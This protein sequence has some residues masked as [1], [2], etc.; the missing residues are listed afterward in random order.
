MI[1]DSLKRGVGAGV[2]AGLAYGLFMAFVGNPLIEYMEHFAH[3]HGHGH[4]PAVS[5]LTTTVVS[6]GSGVLWGILLGTVFGVAYYLLEP[7]L[8]GTRG[9]R[10]TVLAG[11]GFL[12]VSG[13]PWLGLPPATPVTEQALATDT[14]LLVY[15]GLM[16]LGAMMC[17]LSIAAFQRLRTR[18]TALALG[19]ATAPFVLAVL[20]VVL[21]PSGHTDAPG[22]LVTAFQSLVVMSQV[23]IWALIA[24]TYTRLGRGDLAEPS[25]NDLDESHVVTGD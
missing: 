20:P 9:W 3:D 21:V 7:A 6:I 4:G 1:F 8:P 10:A 18:G 23:G 17:A 16:A 19:A 12:T 14:R 5:E 25:T 22:T 13:V 24:A 11:A 2:V 15:A